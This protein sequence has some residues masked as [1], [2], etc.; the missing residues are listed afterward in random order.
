M[1]AMKP[2]DSHEAP[3]AHGG[4]HGRSDRFYWIVA[5]VLAVVTALEVGLF[6]INEQELIAKWLVIVLLLIL[7]TIKGAAVVMFFMH[8]R[9]D[10]RVMK[11]VFIVPFSFAVTLCIAFLLIFRNYAGIAG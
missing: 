8:L 5:A 10:A 1:A 7:S 4:E 2:H 9:G 6:L 3:A 11:F